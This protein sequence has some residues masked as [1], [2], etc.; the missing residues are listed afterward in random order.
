MEG[1]REGREERKEREGREGGGGREG[2]ALFTK[3]MPPHF[4]QNV[5][6]TREKIISCKLIKEVPFL[7]AVWAL[8]G[9]A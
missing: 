4:Q 9:F 6:G 7:R 1:G 8:L 5:H 3:E 2:G